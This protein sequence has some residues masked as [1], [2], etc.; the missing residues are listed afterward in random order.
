MRSLAEQPLEMTLV[1]GRGLGLEN[2][3]CCCGTVVES[4]KTAL[5]LILGGMEPGER[6]NGAIYVKAQ[7]FSSPGLHTVYLT[8]CL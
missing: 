5:Q 3:T 4:D 8:Y 2:I 6:Q 7:L 1:S